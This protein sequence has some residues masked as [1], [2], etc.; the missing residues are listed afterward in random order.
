MNVRSDDYL[1]ISY[2]KTKRLLSALFSHPGVGEIFHVA[3]TRPP[4]LISW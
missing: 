3:R 4:S 1:F 2:R